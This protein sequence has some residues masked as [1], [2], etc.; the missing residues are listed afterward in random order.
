MELTVGAIQMESRNHDV[1]GNLRRAIPL[2][3]EA[4][5]KGATLICL[6][7]FL[8]SGYVFHERSRCG[9]PK[10]HL[11]WS[12]RLSPLVAVVEAADAR[13]RGQRGRW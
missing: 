13:E 1:E 2:L 8:P 9:S 3:E 12:G 5:E 6:P 10:S 11:R 4:A 7:E